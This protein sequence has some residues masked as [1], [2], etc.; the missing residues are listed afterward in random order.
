MLSVLITLMKEISGDIFISVTFRITLQILMSLWRR[1]EKSNG[2]WC[3]HYCGYKDKDEDELLMRSKE[4][5]N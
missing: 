2:S 4:N 1:V 5:E 3:C